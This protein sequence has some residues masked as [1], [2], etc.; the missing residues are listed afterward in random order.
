MAIKPAQPQPTPIPT[1]IGNVGNATLQARGGIKNSIGGQVI[2]NL[3]NTFKQGAQNVASDITN[4]P[5]LA[6]EAGGGIIPS[7]LAS[8]ATAGHVA[9]D[10]A[11]TAGGIISSFISPLLPDS[12]KSAIGNLATNITNKIKSS[13]LA[14][15]QIKGLNDLFNTL[16]LAGG[17]EVEPIVTNA[18]KTGA[19]AVAPVLENATEKV[20]QAGEKISETATN[21]TSKVGEKVSEIVKGKN[22]EKVLATPEEDVPKLSPTERKA[23]FDNQKTQI[24]TQHEQVNQQIK[25]DLQNKALAS[26]TEAENLQKQLAT[27]T[28]DKVVELRP[29]ILQSMGKQSATYR[30]LVEE[31]LAPHAN[32]V[33]KTTDLNSY[34]DN[35]FADNPDM[36]NAVKQKLG[37]VEQVKTATGVETGLESGN[38]PRVKAETTLGDLYNQTKELRQGIGKNA[39]KVFSASDKLTDDAISTLSDYMKQNGVDLKD[40]NSFWSKYAP[41]RDQLVKEA[42]PF[43]QTGT[44][45]KTFANTLMR[46]ARGT[47]VNNEN[48]INEVENLVSEPINDEAKGIVSKLDANEKASLVDK[49]SADAKKLDNQ[50]ARDN[51][52]KNLSAKQFEI[53][54]QARFRSIVKKAIIGGLGLFGAKELGITKFFG[55]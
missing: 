14:P 37:T 15:E 4:A 13:G 38:V 30:S 39:G 20:G 44:Q 31:E 36:A 1:S 19:E 8:F 6:K 50:M 47:D 23:W 54:R 27:T 3:G 32:D 42:K 12:A 5:N 51:S 40:A 34:I 16:T 33:V 41:I 48:F 35:R 45:T 43:L 24:E 22:L 11:G 25:T 17:E 26:Q 53:E 10:I 29:K 28:R 7:E 18:V 49:M 9:G 55:L 46:V 21:A 52:L 2:S